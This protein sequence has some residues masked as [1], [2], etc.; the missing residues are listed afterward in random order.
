MT[1]VLETEQLSKAFGGVQA[2]NRVD[3]RVRAGEVHGLVGQNGAGKSTLVK[4]LNGVYPSGSYGGVIRLNGAE[5][6]FASPHD[7][8]G[9]GIAYVPQEL[10]M[11]PNLSVAENIFVGQTG[12]GRHLWVRFGDLY[13]AATEI[14]R[15]LGLDLQ[16]RAPITSLSAAQRQL[17]MVARALAARPTVLMLDEP[18]ASLSTRETEILFDVLNRLRAEGV[19]MVFITHRIP[20]VMALSDHAT[21]LRDGQVVAEIERGQF[22]ETDLVSAMV[23]RRIGLLYPTRDAAV[24]KEEALRVEH[25]R[26]PHPLGAQDIIGD[27]SFSIRRGEIVGLAGLV[28]S[29]RT[30]LLGAIYGRIRHEGRVLVDGRV[31]DVPS[32]AAARKAG[33]AMLTE[34]RKNDGL[35]FNFTLGRNITVGNLARLSRNWVIDRRAESRG[36]R[37]FMDSLSIKAPSPE[38]DVDHLSGGNQQKVLLARVMMR[39]PRILLL[40]EPTKGV[41]VGT[42]HEIY[43]LVMELARREVAL[44]LVSTELPE[45]IGLCDRCLVLA[46]GVIVDEFEKADGSEERVLR[47]T[48]RA[49]P[50]TSERS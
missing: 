25:L 14:L 13:A 7:A 6:H 32:P 5:C 12:R 24:G 45:L 36:A 43:R 30:E 44:L 16:P 2:L 23:G 48:A 35:L 8:R 39:A 38:S 42:K 34:D 29:G 4:I 15:R 40:D 22:S 9:R 3:F 28:G 27:V 20:E 26:V 41:D 10:Q 50:R 19:T 1:Y 47:A 46:N 33:I 37:E 17:V 11:L 31:V 21:V 18:T 49:S